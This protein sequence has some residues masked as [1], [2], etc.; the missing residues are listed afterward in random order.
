MRHFI[1][2]AVLLLLSPGCKGGGVPDASS[3]IPAAAIAMDAKLKTSMVRVLPM[4]AN[5]ESSLVF[6]LNPGTPMAQGVTVQPDPTPGAP[7]HSITF[8]GPYDGNGDGID[9]TT[10]S[11]RATFNGDPDFSWSGLN[12][13]VAVDVDIPIVGHVYHADVAFT[14]TSTERRLSGSGAFTDPLSGNRTTMTVDAATPLVVKP[15]TGAAGAVSNAC[16][17][18]LDG[19][20]RLSVEGSTGTLR[21]TWNFSSN[22][23]G[24]AI[25]SASF[26]D[27]SGQT[28]ALPA[29]TVDLTCG[30]SGSINDWVATFD[31][32]YACMPR[33]SG[34]ATITITVAGPNSITIGDEDPPGSGDV[35]TYAAT[36]VAAN[37]HAVRGFFNGGPA[38]NRYREDFNWTLGKNGGFSQVSIYTYFEG[39]NTGSSGLCVASAR[40]R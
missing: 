36:I 17:H 22:N 8:S 21:S 15:A 32:N 2:P 12:G 3:A 30:S 20:M 31:Q 23:P 14:V 5:I 7:P 16:G 1:A 25:S 9:E 39:P 26:T 19:P 6:V 4:V 13:Q 27:P 28:T 24:A 38:G 34:Q 35:K 18:S 33:E 40:K 29:S 11:G 37:P 10:M